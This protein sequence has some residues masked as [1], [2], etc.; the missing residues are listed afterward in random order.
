M[1]LRLNFSGRFT[2]GE[3]APMST[4]RRCASTG[5]GGRECRSAFRVRYSY[6]YSTLARGH[7]CRPRRFIRRLDLGFYFGGVYWYSRSCR[8]ACHCS[9]RCGIVCMAH[10]GNSNSPGCAQCLMTSCQGLVSSRLGEGVHCFGC[11]CSFGS[12]AHALGRI[13]SSMSLNWS[14]QGRDPTVSFAILS[15]ERLETN[16]V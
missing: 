13:L 4:G 14:F 3:S 6:R 2:P 5:M 9:W 1:D 12:L 10:F 7:G 15:S 11:I 16:A 8:R